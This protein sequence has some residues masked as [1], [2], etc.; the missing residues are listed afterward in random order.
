MSSLDEVMAHLRT[1]AMALIDEQ[2]RRFIGTVVDLGVMTR[3]EA[4]ASCAEQHPTVVEKVEQA[5]AEW[6]EELR[7]EARTVN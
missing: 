6:R 4:E 3:A 2:E 1:R 5:L 7:C